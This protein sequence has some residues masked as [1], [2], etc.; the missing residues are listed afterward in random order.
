MKITCECGNESELNVTEDYS[1]DE[2]YYVEPDDKFRLWQG[3]DVVGL[4][5]NKCGKE[6]WTFV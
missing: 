5:C 4:V 2:G 1:E 6:L 3:H